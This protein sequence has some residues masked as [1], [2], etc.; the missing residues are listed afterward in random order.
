MC[1][2]RCK[3]L[4]LPAELHIPSHIYWP[5]RSNKT[6]KYALSPS[7]LRNRRMDRVQSF[8]VGKY[9]VRQRSAQ[10]GGTALVSSVIAL[11]FWKRVSFSE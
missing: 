3:F 7:Q 2:G 5:A 9:P 4:L 1:L 6:P 8:A 11:G 10:V